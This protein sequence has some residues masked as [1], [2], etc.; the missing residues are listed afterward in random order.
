MEKTFC[1]SCGMDMAYGTF[2]KNADGTTS[3]DY[4]SYCFID[5]AFNSPNITLQGMIDTCAPIL[6]D[7][8]AFATVEAATEMLSKHLPTLKRWK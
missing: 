6:V 2:G 8:K 3:A 1:Q 4:C 5:G 7:A